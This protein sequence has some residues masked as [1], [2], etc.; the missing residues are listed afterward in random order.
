MYLY[1]VQHAEAKSKDQDSKRGLTEKGLADIKKVSAHA[2]R[3]T[4]F[5]VGVVTHSGK[6]RAEQTATILAEQWEPHAGVIP[7]NDLDP[8]ADPS[9]WGERLSLMDNDTMLVGHLP[10]LSKLAGLLICGDANVEPIQFKNAGIVCLEK[11]ENGNWS[12]R[13][14]LTPE[15][16]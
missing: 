12:L 9:I 6:A 7:V 5:E 16:V 2:A 8:T 10:H 4:P 13:W 1:L 15:Q 3:R 11:D 14:M